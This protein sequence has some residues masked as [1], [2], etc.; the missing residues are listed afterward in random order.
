MRREKH[1]PWKVWPQQTVFLLQDT[2]PR[3]ATGVQ[4]VPIGMLS[5][6]MSTLRRPSRRPSVHESTLLEFSTFWQHCAPGVAAV[7]DDGGGGGVQ[8][9]L[10]LTMTGT[11]STPMRSA[12][13]V[14]EQGANQTRNKGGNRLT[15]E[16][17]A[18][19]DLVRV[20]RHAAEDVDGRAARADG[21]VQAGDDDAEQAGE[22]AGVLC[23]KVARV[24]DVLAAL[25]PRRG[26][27][28]VRAREGGDGADEG[29]G[30]NESLGEHVAW[31]VRRSW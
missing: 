17:L 22:D 13:S 25:R 23:V 31:L 21:N 19:L 6:E 7:H 2:P 27:A 20:A 4:P 9:R 16:D 10:V 14:C 29:K 26:R 11:Q 3:M 24:R 30:S 5:A 18:A 8:V 12:E 28:A 1:R 15:L